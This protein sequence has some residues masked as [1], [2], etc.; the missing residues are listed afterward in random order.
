M[1]IRHSTFGR[2]LALGAVAV[3]AVGVMA[4]GSIAGEP[5]PG[6]E[7]R[8]DLRLTRA[9]DSVRATPGNYHCVPPDE[10]GGDG[11]CRDRTPG[12]LAI[13][14]RLTVRGCTA[15]K[16]HLGYPAKRIR[17]TVLS[18]SLDRVR[19]VQSPKPLKASNKHFRFR[20]PGLPARSERLGFLVVHEDDNFGDFEAGIVRKP[21]R[22]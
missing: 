11:Y 3:L 22:C 6:G 17:V 12:P 1:A 18:K 7:P 10:P 4:S 5:N 2:N 16:I 19:R 9:G 15:V 14:G 8:L 13:F 21:N 20:L